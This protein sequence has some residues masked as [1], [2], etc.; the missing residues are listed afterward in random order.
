MSQK[1]TS[2]VAA[3]NGPAGGTKQAQPA[4]PGPPAPAR[5]GAYDSP[6]RRRLPLLPALLFLIVVTQAPFVATLVISFIDWKWPAA[7]R[8]E[9]RGA[10]ELPRR[11]RR[12]D[13]RSAIVTTVLLTV[14]VVLVALVIGFAL[15]LLLNEK[16]FGR[17]FVRTLL[18]TP[19]LIVPVAAALVWKHLLLNPVYGLFNGILTWIG[20]LFGFDAPRFDLISDHPLLAVEVALIWQWTPFMMLILLAGLQSLPG[21]ALE[22]SKIDGASGW[23]TF[24]HI[25]LPHMRQYLELG[26]LLGAIYI[27]QAFDAVF[28]ITAGAKGAANLPYVI[29]EEFFVAQDYGVS[30]AIGVITVIGTIIIATFALRSVSSLLQEEGR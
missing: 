28:T 15:A 9:V 11:A 13:L 8:P 12:S 6:A 30:S 23:Q 17:G 19:F 7:R 14:V 2:D 29:Y 26:A 5:A 16:F 18:I 22:A 4:P 27:V 21:D 3:E 24:V 1:T 25:T 20:D 10:R